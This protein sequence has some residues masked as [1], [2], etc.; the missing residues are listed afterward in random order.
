MNRS[1]Q[2]SGDEYTPR[3]EAKVEYLNEEIELQSL[4]CI[5]EFLG[6]ETQTNDYEYE[7]N[8]YDTRSDLRCKIDGS[9]WRV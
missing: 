5:G 4:Q 1:Q 8:C 7:A 2:S 3:N 9:Q 6:L